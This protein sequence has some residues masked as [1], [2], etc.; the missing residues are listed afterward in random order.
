[1]VKTE[2]KNRLSEVNPFAKIAKKTFLLV[3]LNYLWWFHDI[4]ILKDQKF[5]KILGKTRTTWNNFQNF[6]FQKRGGYQI[7]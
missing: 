3:R 6:A 5:G 7:K 1:M 2:T 4:Q